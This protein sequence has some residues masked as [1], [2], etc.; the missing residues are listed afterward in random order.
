VIDRCDKYGYFTET[1]AKV[2]PK[3]HLSDAKIT[4]LDRELDCG[5]T[6]V[7]ACVL[8]MFDKGLQYDDP[9]AVIEQLKLLREVRL[10]GKRDREIRTGVLNDQNG[11]KS[12]SNAPAAISEGDIIHDDVDAGGGSP[13]DDD[14][15]R[16]HDS[17]VVH[18][19]PP[20][21]PK[22]CDVPPLALRLELVASSGEPVGV[23]TALNSWIALTVSDSQNK[24]EANGAAGDAGD[25]NKLNALDVLFE[26]RALDILISKILE[27][28]SRLA[29]DTGSL[30]GKVDTV[31]AGLSCLLQNAIILPQNQISTTRSSPSI[32]LFVGSL[33]QLLQSYAVSVARHAETENDLG[34]SESSK[35]LAT[36]ASRISAT[37]RR[38]RHHLTLSTISKTVNAI[39]EQIAAILQTS[40][41]DDVLLKDEG[42]M[43]DRELRMRDLAITASNIANRGFAS[44][45]DEYIINKNDIQHQTVE[46]IDTFA[47][48]GKPSEGE[49]SLSFEI[50]ACSNAARELSERRRR[51]LAELADIDAE[52]AKVSSRRSEL[53]AIAKNPTSSDPSDSLTAMLR[54]LDVGHGHGHD[55]GHGHG[56]DQDE[57]LSPAR[58]ISCMARSVIADAKCIQLIARRIEQTRSR[59]DTLREEAAAYQRLGMSA[60]Q[61]DTSRCVDSL[62]SSLDADMASLNHLQSEMVSTIT[63]FREFVRERLQKEVC[64]TF[65]S[66]RDA[67]VAVTADSRFVQ[68]PQAAAVQ[69]EKEMKSA[70]KDAVHRV[71]G[72]SLPVNSLLISF[73]KEENSPVKAAKSSAAAE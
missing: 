45:R 32:S 38:F 11:L 22:N 71:H 27:M 12:P 23:L 1:P 18:P 52:L 29:A 46:R 4:Y 36:D 21:L 37:I 8:S 72:L 39:D 40:G 58:V 9:E 34:Q 73:E 70:V 57:V 31:R 19:D 61:R 55:H 67:S 20:S 49:E 41:A 33:V 53:E 62:K 44:L 14:E 66:F 48:K 10:R 50:A 42:K 59:H 56:A 2:Q 25:C 65:G 54:E 43:I 28:F 6:K 35:R 17:D 60:T 69:A 7:S 16:Y 63:K 68:S 13:S 24:S 47:Q 5:R 30:D 3:N 51:L 15:E 26:C 64:I